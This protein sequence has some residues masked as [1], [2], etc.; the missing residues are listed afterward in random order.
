L[1]LLGD[2]NESNYKEFEAQITKK[3]FQDGYRIVKG[4]GQS[5]VFVVQYDIKTGKPISG[6]ARPY[7][8]KIMLELAGA[9]PGTT[10]PILNKQ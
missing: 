10:L 4:K 7:T 9:K 1:G 3:N 8:N 6:T 2:I 5:G